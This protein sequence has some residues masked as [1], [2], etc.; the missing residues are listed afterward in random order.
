MEEA[1][2]KIDEVARG[3]AFRAWPFQLRSLCTTR[4]RAAG[5]V[6]EAGDEMDKV[7]RGLALHGRPFQLRAQC[8]TRQDGQA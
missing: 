3:F 7:A 6:A 8:T 1:G 5:R 4:Q 2:D